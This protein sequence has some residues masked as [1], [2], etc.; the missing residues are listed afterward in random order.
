MPD[1]RPGKKQKA[2]GNKQKTIGKQE[3]PLFYGAVV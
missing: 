1:A 3:A 2:K